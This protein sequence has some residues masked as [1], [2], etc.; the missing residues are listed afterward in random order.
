MEYVGGVLLFVIGFL[1]AF[2]ATRGWR[3]NRSSK[4]TIHGLQAKGVVRLDLLDGN[5]RSRGVST[6]TAETDLTLSDGESETISG[7]PQSDP[8]SGG[9]GRRE[10][11]R[12]RKRK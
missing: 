7:K 4:I 9:N 5:K 3:M 6:V 1:T 11:L 12:S 10:M 8:V 2:A